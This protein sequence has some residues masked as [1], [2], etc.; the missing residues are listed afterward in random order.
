[1]KATLLLALLLPGSGGDALAEKYQRWLEEE[2]PYIVSQREKKE[3]LALETDAQREAFVE[4]FW[5]RRDPDP[6]TENN[7]FRE[8]H[9]RR[10]EHANQ[11][12]GNEGRPGWKTE[13][14]RIYII[15]GPPD[16]V[17]YSFGRRVRVTV[18]RPTSPVSELATV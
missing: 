9:Y 6:A 3:F 14:G 2:V 11:R 10:I 1:M 15:H 4:Y 7:E 5:S 17:R 13:R 12:F 18:H 8:E 16:D